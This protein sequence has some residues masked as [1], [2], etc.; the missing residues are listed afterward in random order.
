MKYLKNLSL[1]KIAI[2]LILNIYF[3]NILMFLLSLLFI[4]LTSNK[5]IYIFIAG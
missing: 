1:F 2:F 5:D 4:L 3:Q